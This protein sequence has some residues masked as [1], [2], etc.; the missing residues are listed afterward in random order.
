MFAGGGQD[1]QLI[2]WDIGCPK[3]EDYVAD[4]RILATFQV[5]RKSGSG[6]DDDD[7]VECVSFS[8]D[9]LR[10]LAGFESGKILELSLS[11]NKNKKK[12]NDEV[13]LKALN[14]F[15]SLHDGAVDGAQ[16]LPNKR[17]SE[18]LFFLL[19]VHIAHTHTHMQNIYNLNFPP[20]LQ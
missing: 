1:G 17:I 15:S 10:V 16:Y 3:G 2:L 8:D 4:H 14:T 18:F 19:H 11:V 12:K 6:G 20:H 13:E 9:G 5:S 7:G